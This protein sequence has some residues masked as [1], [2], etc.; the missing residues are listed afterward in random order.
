MTL[1]IMGAS[2]TIRLLA[3][4][5][6][7]SLVS[8]TAAAAGPWS[9][10]PEAVSRLQE[11]PRDRGALAVLEV[12]ERALLEEAEAGHLASVAALLDAYAELVAPLSG[13]DRRLDALQR[14]TA[15]AL[16]THGDGLY[17]LDETGAGMTWSLAAGI[18]PEPEVL[19]R[20]RVLLLPP[21][22]ARPGQVWASPVDGAEMVFLPVFR[23]LM[24]C[25]HGDG[26]CGPDE[27][28][29]RWVEVPGLW[30]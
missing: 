21:A 18:T 16:L 1:T 22:E 20:L 19:D 7:G 2:R 24:G 6:A 26:E 23:F 13:A 17:P 4:L 15:M 5:M 27:I 8:M 29:L 28:Y 3:L 9:Q 10:L 30:V 12:A 25:T 14:R 11:R